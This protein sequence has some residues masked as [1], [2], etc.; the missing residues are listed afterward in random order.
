M[1]WRRRG[2][3]LVCGA[4]LAMTCLA[5]VPGTGSAFPIKWWMFPTVGDPDGP[6]GNGL[7]RIRVG[8]LTLAFISLRT[9]GA[10]QVF[11]LPLTATKDVRTGPIR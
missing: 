9:S 11:I 3:A 2:R 10:Y 6:S 4:L 7:L 5:T 8:S 1:S